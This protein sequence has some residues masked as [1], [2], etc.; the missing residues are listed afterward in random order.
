[1]GDPGVSTIPERALAL[2]RAGAVEDAFRL[3]EQACAAGDGLAAATLADWRM[4][5]QLVRRDIAAA[6]TL[7]GRALEL[8]VEAAAG[9]YLALLASGAGD[10]P[11]DWPATLALL[12]GRAHDPAARR[13]AQLLAAME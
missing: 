2:A 10:A 11:R 4:T 1:M 3:L 7:Y 13:Q 5:G 8:G 9:P 6:R 12:A